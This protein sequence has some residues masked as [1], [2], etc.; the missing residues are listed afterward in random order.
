V[1]PSIL[2]SGGTSEKELIDVTPP[3]L[4]KTKRRP[5]PLTPSS[6][7]YVLVRL[8]TKKGVRLSRHLCLQYVFV[9]KTIL[10]DG[11]VLVK[12]ISWADWNH[13]PMRTPGDQIVCFSNNLGTGKC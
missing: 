9:L 6:T 13:P 12:K 5:A 11:R 4:H 7:T 2:L 10:Q 1:S 3:D 8:K